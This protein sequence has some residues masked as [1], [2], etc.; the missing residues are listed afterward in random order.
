MTGKI[1][2]SRDTQMDFYCKFPD[3]AK[4]DLLPCP[5]SLMQANSSIHERV[6]QYPIANFW[7]EIFIVAIKL[8]KF[9]VVKVTL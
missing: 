7:F 8:L 2:E 9:V 5:R 6:L 4:K 3:F 1:F